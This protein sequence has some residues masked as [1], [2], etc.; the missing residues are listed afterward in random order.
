MHDDVGL[1]STSTQR[2]VQPFVRGCAGYSNL[3][4]AGLYFKRSDSVVQADT[5]VRGHSDLEYV[6]VTPM[7]RISNPRWASTGRSEMTSTA[8]RDAVALHF[9]LRLGIEEASRE[10]AVD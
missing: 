6:L 9:V 7:S 2:A 5:E 3:S 10:L 8:V 1:R 4:I